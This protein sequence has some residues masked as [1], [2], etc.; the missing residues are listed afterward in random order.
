MKI[1]FYPHVPGEI[2]EKSMLDH[3]VEP[4]KAYHLHMI[5]DFTSVDFC[6]C[7]PVYF[8][9]EKLLNDFIKLEVTGFENPTIISHEQN[10]QSPIK[11]IDYNFFMI[12]IKSEPTNDLNIFENCLYISEK[13]RFVLD[14]YNLRFGEFRI[15][16][17]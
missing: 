8:I 10:E 16:E 11:N 1:Q 13:V 12:D 15:I 9:K 2:S 6:S 7:F 17:E 14:N 3:G 5:F 4:F